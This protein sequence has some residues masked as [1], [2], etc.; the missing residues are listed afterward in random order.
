MPLYLSEPALICACGR[1]RDALWQAVTHADNTAIRDSRTADGSRSFPVAL[2]AESELPAAAEPAAKLVR[3]E[4]AALSGLDGRVAEA[5]Q[6]Y[7]ADRIAVIVGSCDNASETSLRGHRQFFQAGSFPAGYTLAQQG[8]QE[9]SAAVRER[10][11][12]RGPAVSCASACSS[13]AAAVVKAAQ[14]IR[15]GIVDAV[16]AGGADLASDLVLLGFASMECISPVATNPF[17]KNRSGITLG[18]A[19]AFFLIARDNFVTDG[20]AV[21]LAG[22]GESADAYHITSP[23]PSGTGAASAMRTALRSAGIGAQELGY[24]NLHGTGTKLNDAM[25]ARA[26]A[27]VTGG[28]VPCSATKSVTGHSLGAAGALSLAV[29]YETLVR[30]AGDIT[31]RNTPPMAADKADALASG[32]AGVSAANTKD[33][34]NALS[35]GKAR[36]V[37][38]AQ[39]WDGVY[40]DELPRLHIIDTH[41]N[42]PRTD[43]PEAGKGPRY[44]M[45]NSFGFGGANVSLI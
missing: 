19:A 25:E 40:D 14:L 1:G 44:C 18:E 36:V 26:V 11:G 33:G 37:L 43:S 15:G 9:V 12:I 2:V 29:C 3:M 5:L 32:T 28:S 6:R 27:A 7:G 22:Y 38:P 24:I 13:S 17:S 4:Q 30:N 39:A 20:P 8:A 42:M 45:S 10:Y 21:T 23:D 16:I 31:V 35:D 34:T 41:N